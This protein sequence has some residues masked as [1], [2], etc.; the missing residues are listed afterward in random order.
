MNPR[1]GL[2]LFAFLSI[3]C[4]YVIERLLRCRV[5]VIPMM[6]KVAFV[7]TTF[8]NISWAY[9]LAKPVLPVSTGVES[10]EQFLTK[11]VTNYRVFRYANNQLPPSA[12]IL[13][14]GIV[15]GYYCDREYLW[16]HPFQATINYE[17]F[18]KPDEL[19]ERMGQLGVTHVV[20]MIHIPSFRQKFFP[21]YFADPFHEEFRKRHLKALYNDEAYVL[22]KVVYR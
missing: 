21:Q 12:R 11:A 3:L 22:F 5:K 13:L 4:G 18:S 16:D 17:D 19:L 15:R 7:A 10:R 1:Y 8:L 9:A 20:R 6:F 14:Q 2:V